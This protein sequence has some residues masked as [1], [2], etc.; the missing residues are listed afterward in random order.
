VP[1]RDLRDPVAYREHGS[2]DYWL[3][4][5]PDRDAVRGAADAY[6]R[7][8]PIDRIPDEHVAGLAAGD[9]EASPAR[10]DP[11]VAR[12]GTAAEP[13]D[14]LPAPAREPESRAAVAVGQPHAARGVELE[15]LE[16]RAD[17]LLQPEPARA[18]VGADL[19]DDP[20]ISVGD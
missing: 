6:A 12:P 14:R 9:H 20:G 15:P 3:R 13:L 16:P 1:D 10:A 2:R 8:V 4:D 19:S 7:R 11:D 18:R 17:E 5:E